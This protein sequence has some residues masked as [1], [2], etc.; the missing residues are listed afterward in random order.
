M[1]QRATFVQ[2]IVGETGEISIFSL[3]VTLR[4]FLVTVNHKKNCAGLRCDPLD[5][6]RALGLR[7]SPVA[8]SALLP[9]PGNCPE[10]GL[11]LASRGHAPG[12]PW[13]TGPGVGSSPGVYQRSAVYGTFLRPRNEVGVQLGYCA[14][15]GWFTISK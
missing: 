4:T 11:G 6:S 12:V 9:I 5:L 13:R 1:G 3:T 7:L 10:G 2:S 14:S 15:F 8:R